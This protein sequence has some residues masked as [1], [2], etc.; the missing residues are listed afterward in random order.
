MPCLRQT[1]ATERPRA[2]SRSASRRSLLICS[3]VLR[4]LMGP[5]WTHP[6]LKRTLITAGPHFGEQPN[7]PNGTASAIDTST[8]INPAPAAV[9]QT[10]R[11]GNFDYTLGGLTPGNSYTVQLDFAEISGNYAG[12]RQFDVFINRTHRVL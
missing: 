8:A 12:T 1:S 9:Y 3:A 10:A 2:R 7:V 5:S 11:Q 6:I 4:L